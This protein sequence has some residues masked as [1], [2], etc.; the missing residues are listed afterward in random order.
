MTILK[1]VAVL[2]LSTLLLTSL[3]GA[4]A[5]Q[6]D[7]HGRREKMMQL[8]TPETM[9]ILWS[10]P[11]R[12]YSGDVNYPYRQDSNLYYLTG[13]E[14]EQTVFMMCPD[15]RD[16]K[17]REMLFLRESSQETETWEG[18]KLTKDEAREISGIRHIYSLGEFPRIFTG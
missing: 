16:E 3:A 1:R 11:E 12:V 8:L 17:H 15:A 18:H 14:Q 6:D 4:A 7:M 9:L 5:F 10:A 2:L 13:I